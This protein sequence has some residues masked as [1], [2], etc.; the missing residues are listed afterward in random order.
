MK[1]LNYEHIEHERYINML[2]KVYIERGSWLNLG[3]HLDYINRVNIC[4]EVNDIPLQKLVTR[5]Q[6]IYIYC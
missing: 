4:D 3:T 1:D 6:Y 5:D 2:S